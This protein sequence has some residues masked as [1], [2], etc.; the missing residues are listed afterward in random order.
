VIVRW[1]LAELPGLLE[2]LG[3]AR[4]FLVASTR[5]DELEIA[6]AER[7]NEIPSQ[8]IEVPGGVDGIVAVGGG[9]AIDTAKAA[10]AAGGLPLVSVPTS[11]RGSSTSRS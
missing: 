5:W 10:S 2:E 4:P 9:S 1:G 7:W 11:W 3:I 8:R 6:A